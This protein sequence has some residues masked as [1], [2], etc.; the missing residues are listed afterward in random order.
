MKKTISIFVVILG[1]LLLAACGTAKQDPTAT[2]E[3]PVI[4]ENV[5]VAEGR[6][7][8]VQF[9]KMSFNTSGVVNEVLIAEGDQVKAGQVLA[10]L[11]NIEAL[12]ADEVKAQEAY[13]LA[14]QTLNLSQPEA[15]KD[16]AKAYETFRS[17]QQKLDD[18]NIPSEFNGMTPSEAVTSTG[19]RVEKARNAYDPYR[20][21]KQSTRFV[22]DLRNNL[23]D[24]WADYNKAVQWMNLEADLDNARIQLDQVKKEYGSLD[25]SA[26]TDPSI[27]RAKFDTAAANLAAAQAALQNAELISPFS[28]TVAGVDIKAG[29]SVSPNQAI[30]TI[31][32]FSSW[33]VKTTDLTEIDVVDIEKGQ[34]ATITLD[35]LPSS[36]LTGEVWSIGQTFAEVQGDVVYEV[37]VKLS[38][39]QPQMRWGMTAKVNL[40]R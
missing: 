4:A 15:L 31:A 6:L 20:N 16:M 8:P 18:F 17:A 21:Y 29:E 2:P 34:S 7:E 26:S 1:T 11:D 28:G 30:I 9:A 38:E 14:Q 10:R 19:A 12:K 3:A 25:T 37:T 33:I 27:A 13:L 22:R 36:P 40:P 5:I 35:A 23:E 24:A 39:S 32:D